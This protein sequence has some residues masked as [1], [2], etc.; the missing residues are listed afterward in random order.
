MRWLHLCRRQ[1]TFGNDPRQPVV[2]SFAGRSGG[3]QWRGRQRGEKLLDTG[4]DFTSLS[5]S[6]PVDDLKHQ[7]GWIRLVPRVGVRRL[8]EEG[9]GVAAGGAARQVLRDVGLDRHLT[10]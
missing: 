1:Q 8:I 3:D 4:G 9:P 5:A 2:R 6:R 10:Y 7:N